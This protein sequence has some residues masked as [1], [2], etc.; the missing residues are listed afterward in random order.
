MV[1]I[2][3]LLTCEAIQLQAKA[4]HAK[5]S[6]VN[7]LGSDVSTWQPSDIKTIGVIIGLFFASI[8]TSACNRNVLI[9]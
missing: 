5:S 6:Q 2:G 8:S 1:D 7:C 9:K 3:Q 4:A